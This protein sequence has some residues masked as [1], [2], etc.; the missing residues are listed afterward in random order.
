MLNFISSN[1]PLTEKI[2]VLKNI[3]Q[4]QA[5]IISEIVVNVLYGVLQ[6]TPYYKRK[7]EPFKKLWH[8]LVKSG[9]SGRKKLI[10]N[11]SKSILLLIKA[12]RKTLRK[13]IDNGIPEN[14]TNSSR[15]V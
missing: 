2:K 14:D 13:L 7:L 4:K 1:A 12:C 6:I 11:H 15:K 9:N 5:K 10:G 3:N 8:K